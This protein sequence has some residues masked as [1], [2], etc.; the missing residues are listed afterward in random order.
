MSGSWGT[1]G[2]IRP[3]VMA[4][5][6]FGARLVSPGALAAGPVTLSRSQASGARA[7]GLAADGV[8]WQDFGADAPRFVGASRR[9]LMEPQRT[10]GVRNP[11]AES[12]T[13]GIIGSG[14]ALPQFW[15]IGTAGL[16]A[17]VGTLTT[18]NGVPVLPVRFFGT[19][20]GTN[21]FIVFE[22]GTGIR[23]APGQPWSAS[24][25][26]Q[27]IA[28]P[29]PPGLHRIVVNPRDAAGSSAGIAG[30]TLEFTP[31]ATLRR[32][33]FEIPAISSDPN[34]AHITHTYD[35]T[36]VVGQA[37][38]WTV[39][40]ALPQLEQAPFA[41]TPILPDIGARAASTRG[42]DILTATADKFTA[43][44]PSGVGTI[45][46][47]ATMSAPSTTTQTL[48]QVDDGTLDNRFLLRVDG[49]S[50]NLNLY[51]VAAAAGAG[52][53]SLG[54][55]TAGAPFRAAL[56]FAP[57][58]EAWASL[59]GGAAVTVAGGPTYG[60]SALRIGGEIVDI[61]AFAEITTV[62]ALPYAIPP[63]DLP[64]ATAAT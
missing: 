37:Y 41:T 55:I 39:G 46:I 16:S 1:L 51:R 35:A 9:L 38:D 14:G 19:A 26:G 49:G 34:V 22:T 54:P 2:L 24:F 30:A 21:I 47:N 52:P 53:F 29:A 40:L 10:N 27:L 59:N 61:F 32:F 64:A 63:A 42:A 45:L 4:A 3:P 50:T 28:A 23:A 25:F 57:T 15:G 60:L 33:A 31:D 36:L 8:T 58:G 5:P 11:R 12:S 62:D 20:T 48:V 56:T 44:F 6:A 17:E 7:T 18:V 43:L 13:P